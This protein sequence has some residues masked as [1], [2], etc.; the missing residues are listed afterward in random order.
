MNQ[1]V[2]TSII[3]KTSLESVTSHFWVASY[4]FFE[5]TLFVLAPLQSCSDQS[6]QAEINVYDPDGELIN[7]VSFG[8]PSNQVGA[9]EVDQLLG[10]CKLESGFKHAHLVIKSP[11]GTRHLCRLHA[12]ER[13]T[14][15]GQPI[16]VTDDQGV[17]FPLTLALNRTSLLCLVNYSD[18]IARVRCRV[19]SAK[20]SPEQ[21]LTIPARGARAVIIESL[22]P[23]MSQ[24]ED[25]KRKTAYLRISAKEGHK[26]GAQL[27][28]RVSC[29]DGR[30]IYSSVN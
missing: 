14:L 1:Q 15:L 12:Q 5:T 19:V 10:A 21:I 11:Q 2:E 7:E 24:V 22:F 30:F 13:A 18:E 25:G 16:S 3:S 28:E 26:V 9:L 23:E 27:L 20:R 4:P 6:S 17:F 29:G 8:F